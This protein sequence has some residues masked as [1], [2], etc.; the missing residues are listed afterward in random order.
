MLVP[1]IQLVV[2]QDYICVDRLVTNLAS[3]YPMQ[4]KIKV[5]SVD[6]MTLKTWNWIQWRG[7]LAIT[8][9]EVYHQDIITS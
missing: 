3:I 5:K 7:Y 6:I 1:R 8:T 2:Y 4:Q 9:Q